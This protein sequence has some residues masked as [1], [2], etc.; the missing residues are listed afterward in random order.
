MKY[1][2]TKD[3]AYQTPKL[4]VLEKVRIYE[5]RRPRDWKDM[6]EDKASILTTLN[7]F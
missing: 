2:V 3:F 6:T 1:C 7:K 5:A 4:R